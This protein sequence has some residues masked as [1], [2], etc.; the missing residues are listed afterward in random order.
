VR[1][2]TG[3]NEAKNAYSKFI[4]ESKIG[5]LGFYFAK[6]NE[7]KNFLEAQKESGAYNNSYIGIKDVMIDKIKGSVQK[8]MDF[9]KN[10]VPKN[11]VIEERWCRVY[12]A[13]RDGISL[14]PVQLYKIKEDYFVY[15]G[16]HRVSVA[17]FLNFLTIEAEVTEFIPST[18]TKENAIY[19]EKF[20]FEKMTGIDGVVFTEANQYER[21]IKEIRDYIGYLK[22]KEQHEVTF[23]E[24]AQIWYEQI[25]YPS[26]KIFEENHI[27]DSFDNRTISDLFIYFLDHKYFESEKKGH[28]VGFSYA[29]I[30]FI[31]F[32]KTN[33][34]NILESIINISEYVKE[35]LRTLQ[36]VDK[37]KYLDPEILR[38]NDILTEVTGLKFDH[39]FL[40]LFEIDEY[41][42]K[43]EI[44]DLTD[45]IKK[46]YEEDF[47]RKISK[48]K[49]KVKKLPE[50][51]RKYM[52]NIVENGEKLFY[53][54]QNYALIYK[55][56]EHNEPGYLEIVANYIID[57]YIP[58]MEII[59]QEESHKDDIREVYYGIQGRYNYL[60][61]YKK[62][63]T[64]EEAA[65]LYFKSN[66]KKDQKIH[67]WFLLKFSNSS[68]SEVLIDYM[69]GKFRMHSRNKDVLD[70]I[71]EK[72]GK[73]KKY[74]TVFKL[75][76][77]KENFEINSKN[78][79]WLQDR[80]KPD[81]ER[82]GKQE[83]MMTY[84]KTQS[85]MESLK[86][87]ENDGFS[88]IDFYADIVAYGNYLGK[89]LAYIDI[90]DLALEYRNR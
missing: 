9:D 65:G 47:L 20:M 16:N 6:N 33:E 41:M 3:F 22:N 58:I 14:P 44:E 2:I 74:G 38:K 4:K 18:D 50:K 10:F 64:M 42:M 8:Y 56:F 48:F 55:K 76:K 82:L 75:E 40:L 24:G 79:N 43:N 29:I 12:M 88:L 26:V 21:V 69:I 73:P 13:L 67:D 51:Y 36:T 7:L 28:D 39:N 72:Y 49:W 57:I 59:D 32:T 81:L 46:W 68:K 19:R 60:L 15:D 25:Y 66:G 54:L 23:L 45:G 52:E 17:N 80:V 71:L 5:F 77:A 1:K 84:F 61:E 63:V 83:D 27:L 11:E 34:N 90:I 35:N 86:E 70:E 53:S 62:D 89:E 31:N 30:D 87:E 85:V 37:R 78:H